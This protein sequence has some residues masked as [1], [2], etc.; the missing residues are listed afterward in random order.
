MA[1]P[2]DSATPTKDRLWDRLSRKWRILRKA[3][4]ENNLREA[5]EE[6]IEE[7]EDTESSIASDER[8]LLGNVLNL[9]DLNAEDVMVPR[10]DIIAVPLEVSEE[11]LLNAFTRS[12]LQRLPVYRST[13]DE[14]VGMVQIQDI[15][16]WKISGTPLHL[17]TIIREVLRGKILKE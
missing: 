11:E 4:S 1:T 12:R 2:S 16:A 13:L 3:E 10:V 6:L 7:S 8:L 5:L 17:K 15:L 9:R 14:V